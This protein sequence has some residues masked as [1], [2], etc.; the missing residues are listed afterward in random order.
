MQPLITNQ[1]LTPTV[2]PRLILASASPARAALLRSA[3]LDF[4]VAVAPDS[5]EAGALAAAQGTGASPEELVL[6]AAR[7]KAEAVAGTLDGR[8]RVILAADTVVV[9]ADGGIVGKGRDDAESAAI[10]RR[11][12]GSRHRVLTGAVVLDM[13]SGRRRELTA[14]T[15]V[16]MAP[17]SDAE[18]AAYVAAGSAADAAGAYRIQEDGTDRFVRVAS[19]SFSN[20]VGL[21]VEEIIRELAA[22]GV[23][24]AADRK[25]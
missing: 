6:A 24:P 7:A 14:S 1:D 25:E 15:T 19:G 13:P 5:A 18:I 20:V 11:L 17:M 10:L 16:E 8:E 21:P 3:G 12:S 22:V 2:G 23:H 4:E 9:A